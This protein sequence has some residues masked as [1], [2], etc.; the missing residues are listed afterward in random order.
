[1]ATL[2]K[3]EQT[4]GKVTY[5]VRW[6]ADGK[7]RSKSFTRH[8]DARRFKAVLEGDLVQGTFLDPKHGQVT[9][10]AFLE[11]HSEALLIDVRVSTRARILG[12]Y[13]THVLP[14]F[15]HLPLNAIT[16]SAV[17]KWV[18]R[19]RET[20]GASSVR[21]NV[22]ALRRL[23]DLAVSYGLIRSNP[24]VAV[25]LP[26]EPKHEQRFLTH[27]EAWTL[28]E[29]IAPRF[30][31]MVLVAVFGGLRLG[32]VTGLQR[33]H[34]STANCT[35]SVKR[36]LVEVGSSV[37]FGPP[38]TKS[39]VRTVTIP[40]SIMAELAEHLDRYTGENPEALVFT[41]L[42]GQALS[43]N[44]WY[45]YYWKTAVDRAGLTGLRFH[46]LRHTF[47]ALWVDAGRNA[48][49]VSKAAGHSSVA[50]T[51]DRYGHLYDRDDSGLADE[52]DSLL[53]HVRTRTH[54]A[55]RPSP[56]TLDTLSAVR[57]P[58]SSGPGPRPFTADGT[59]PTAGE[60][61]QAGLESGNPD[62]DGLDSS[63]TH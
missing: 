6:W 1:M 43:R 13:K 5:R 16:T 38:K 28:A 34:I 33:Q 60:F 23:L 9:L 39:S 62:Q 18:N 63:R 35:I 56:E 12:I 10:S 55:T 31:A 40:R 54:Q 37:T 42:K 21:K 48:K 27:D 17:A 47:V 57:P 15:G 24:V 4:P 45:R 51:L 32:E 30:R 20:L 2:E 7:Q 61:P 26:A 25:K 19:L 50:F 11:E 22:F 49:E 3:R 36:T 59:N 53:G 8:E 52:L 14:E 44:W 46:D 29:S 58:S 41:A